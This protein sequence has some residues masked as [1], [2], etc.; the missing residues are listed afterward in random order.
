MNWGKVPGKPAAKPNQPTTEPKGPYRQSNDQEPVSSN[1][2]GPP[3]KARQEVRIK[4][5][6]GLEHRKGPLALK[7]QS[8]IRTVDVRTRPNGT[9]SSTSKDKTKPSTSRQ[10]RKTTSSSPSHRP[11]TPT[12][13]AASIASS[14]ISLPSTT[15]LGMRARP[16]GNHTP[17]W[18]AEIHRTPTIENK[19]TPV[20]SL[21]PPKPL[22]HLLPS[23]QKR[24]RDLGLTA[25]LRNKSRNIH[26]NESTEP[27]SKSLRQS[28]L[29]SPELLGSE[30][31]H[32]ASSPPLPTTKKKPKYAELSTQ[33]IYDQLDDDPSL[34]FP[35]IELPST[36]PPPLAQ[37]N[38]RLQTQ[39]KPL[40]PIRP[41]TPT[42][43]FPDKS[44]PPLSPTR[45]DPDG[46][47][48]MNSFLAYCHKKFN[49]PEKQVIYAIERAS[50]IKLLVELVLQSI[51]D[52]N[53]LPTHV[54]G[55]WSEGDDKVLMGADS[56]EMKKLQERKG[57]AHMERRME[58][59]NLWNMAWLLSRDGH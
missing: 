21:S 8:P 30:A 25:E 44:P 46:I 33:A 3:S 27:R 10:R 5:E 24:K 58:F 54:P 40:T 57:A 34:E 48:E 42:P 41:S 6:P 47:R 28:R 43:V 20:L 4:S 53:P 12:G 31:H 17:R 22:S 18:R 26:G 13:R 32:L 38:P 51:V 2:R 15:P 7:T 23:N 39:Q 37:S 11:T 55:V 45:S 35:E 16:S 49:A 19:D 14:G 56:R 50:G 29:L 1:N 36:P 9:P 59:L 52:D